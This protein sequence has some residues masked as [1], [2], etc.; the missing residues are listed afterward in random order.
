LVF[1]FLHECQDWECVPEDYPVDQAPYWDNIRFGVARD[2][3]VVGDPAHEAKHEIRQLTCVPTP[4]D[5]PA[6]I[7]FELATDA[8]VRLTVFD[9]EGAR[10][11]ILLGGAFRERGSYAVPWD[12][13]DDRGITVAPGVYFVR[14]EAAGEARVT[15]TVLAR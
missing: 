11:R 6:T 8:R 7:R 10:T 4:S 5:R 14:L 9:V 2:I 13:T 3:V 12:G 15:R 1:E